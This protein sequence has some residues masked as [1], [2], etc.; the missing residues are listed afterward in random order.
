MDAS[1]DMTY[2]PITL[3]RKSKN[4]TVKSIKT[5]EE[6]HT[7][8]RTESVKNGSRNVVFNLTAGVATARD[9]CT[10]GE[11]HYTCRGEVYVEANVTCLAKDELPPKCLITHASSEL[12]LYHGKMLFRVDP[13]TEK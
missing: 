3:E 4:N 9:G 1:S 5:E 12:R 8:C 13:T 6:K 11:G 7:R 2:T 10:T